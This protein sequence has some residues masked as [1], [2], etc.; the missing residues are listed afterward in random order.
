MSWVREWS[1]LPVN[2]CTCV[3]V[4]HHIHRKGTARVL[5]K[6]LKLVTSEKGSTD[7]SSLVVWFVYFWIVLHLLQE[8]FQAV[9]YNWT[10]RKGSVQGI[11]MTTWNHR[12]PQ[13]GRDLR[14]TYPTPS[15]GNHAP[16]VWT[17]SVNPH[18]QLVAEIRPELKCLGHVACYWTWEGY[19][20]RTVR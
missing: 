18:R 2:V 5:I 1:R 8:C 6:Q 15:P 12:P 20:C 10:N 11:S 16:W 9:F 4:Q 7:V 17:N 14:I 19:P 13:P 3:L